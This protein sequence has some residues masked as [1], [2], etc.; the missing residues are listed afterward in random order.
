MAKT[1]APT[2]RSHAWPPEA[3]DPRLNRFLETVR[4]RLDTVETVGA[5]ALEH[6]LG[7]HLDVLLQNQAIGDYLRLHG[8]TFPGG[9]LVRTNAGLLFRDDFDRPDSADIGNGWNEVGGIG[10]AKLLNGEVVHDSGQQAVVAR[11]APERVVPLRVGAP[12]VES[13]RGHGDNG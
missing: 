5:P 2:S 13:P 9:S 12:L 4:K 1:D 10:Q 8:F 6:R 7:D 3:A 11:S